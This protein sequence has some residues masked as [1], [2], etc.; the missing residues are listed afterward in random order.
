MFT[1]LESGW[2]WR[3]GGWNEHKYTNYSPPPLFFRSYGMYPGDDIVGG[4]LCAPVLQCHLVLN[5]SNTEHP[6]D[7]NR[8]CEITIS[9]HSSIVCLVDDR[10]ILRS[11]DVLSFSILKP[12]HEE[13]RQEGKWLQRCSE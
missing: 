13:G 6:L 3:D 11:F 9:I 7:L 5:S 1:L 8:P 12:I 2:I 10:S 4:A